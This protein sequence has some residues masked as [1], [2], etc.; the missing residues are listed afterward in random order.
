MNILGNFASENWE[1][2]FIFRCNGVH[3]NKCVVVLLSNLSII[4]RAIILLSW[5]HWCIEVK[6]RFLSS[7]NQTEISFIY[8]YNLG[9]VQMISMIEF[10]YFIKFI[11]NVFF[12][13]VMA[14]YSI[15]WIT[16]WKLI[17]SFWHSSN[18][19]TYNFSDRSSWLIRNVK[20][21]ARFTKPYITF[22][23]IITWNTVWNLFRINSWEAVILKWRSFAFPSKV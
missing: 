6:L 10:S 7:T 20:V 17:E 14:L 22:H 11:L 18:V 13:W 5:Q 2:S 9:E 21:E 3:D 8:L 1:S 16:L 23:A 19:S 15:H 4:A 12:K